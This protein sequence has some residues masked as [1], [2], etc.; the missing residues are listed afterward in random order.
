MAGHMRI[1]N[2]PK[3]QEPLDVVKKEPQPE[4]YLGFVFG[5][6]G[7]IQKLE[8]LRMDFQMLVEAFLVASLV[9]LAMTIF[10]LAGS[11]KLGACPK[12][13]IERKGE[14]WIP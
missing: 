8:N 3:G 7:M 11:C 6:A 12:E 14:S 1:W 5:R 13:L 9:K 4:Q 2:W 10:P